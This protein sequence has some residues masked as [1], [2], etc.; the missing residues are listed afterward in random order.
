MTENI[1]VQNGTYV[2][3]GGAVTVTGL[4]GGSVLTVGEIITNIPE[5]WKATI[6]NVVGG[7]VSLPGDDVVI[8]DISVNGA[9]LEW[10]NKNTED[11]TMETSYEGCHPE[12]AESLKRGEHIECITKTSRVKETIIAYLSR[13]NKPYVSSAGIFL[14]YAEPITTETYVIDA[15]SMMQGLVDRGYTYVSEGQWSTDG[16][17][18]HFEPEWWGDC[19]KV[20]RCSMPDWMLIEKETE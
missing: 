9:L 4:K 8:H 14:S 19:G 17:Y 20:K 3:I 18:E 2:E 10:T 11:W 7:G 1:I 15:V 13:S 12:I 6:S 16:G 5:G